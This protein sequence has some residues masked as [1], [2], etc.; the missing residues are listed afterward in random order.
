V[1]M[2]WWTNLAGLSLLRLMQPLLQMRA[3]NQDV[4]GADWQLLFAR[5]LMR[6]SVL[7]HPTLLAAECEQACSRQHATKTAILD[8]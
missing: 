6:L 4:L 3:P 8:P 1:T 2:W 7:L 5:P